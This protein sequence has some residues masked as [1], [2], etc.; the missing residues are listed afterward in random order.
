MGGIV[1][2]IAVENDLDTQD[3]LEIIGDGSLNFHCDAR[4]VVLHCENDGTVTGKKENAGGIVGWASMGLLRECLNTGAVEAEDADYV[5]GIAG[6]R[7]HSASE[8]TRCPP[9]AH[10]T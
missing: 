9:A 8:H 2:A 10:G 1:G 7:S 6:R 5:G 3:D 4:A